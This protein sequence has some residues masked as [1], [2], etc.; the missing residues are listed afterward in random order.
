MDSRTVISLIFI[1]FML[2]FSEGGWIDGGNDDF[3]CCSFQR[4]GGLMG[5]MMC[6]KFMNSTLCVSFN[7]CLAY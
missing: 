1:F 2:Q 6:F 3:S 5:G 4:E 7:V